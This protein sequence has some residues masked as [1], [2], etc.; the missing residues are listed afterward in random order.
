MNSDIFEND[1]TDWQ[2]NCGDRMAL[3]NPVHNMEYFNDFMD[4]L[5][6]SDDL[7]EPIEDDY[8]S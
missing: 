6:G 8:E 7:V 1:G 3:L 2:D 5:I 4:R